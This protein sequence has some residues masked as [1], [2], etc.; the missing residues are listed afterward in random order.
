VEAAHLVGRGGVL[1]GPLQRNL[2]RLAERLEAE[3]WS[4]V[5]EATLAAAVGVSVGYV[6]LNIRNLYLLGTVLLSTPLWRQFDPGAVLDGWEAGGRGAAGVE[7]D[8]EEL[9][10]I[11][12]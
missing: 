11:L 2:D 10:P 5:E 4:P 8:E 9:R 1:A 6:A 12:G 7:D 3:S